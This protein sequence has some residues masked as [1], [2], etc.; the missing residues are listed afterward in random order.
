MHVRTFVCSRHEMYIGPVVNMQ[1]AVAIVKWFAVCYTKHIYIKTLCSV[2]NVLDHCNKQVS[3]KSY[4]S[5]RCASAH[6]YA[7][8]KDSEWQLNE[9]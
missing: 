3:I 9:K 2:Q 8:Q 5:W 4:T 7:Q 6:L 1:V